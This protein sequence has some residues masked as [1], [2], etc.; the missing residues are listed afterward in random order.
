MMKKLSVLLISALALM[1][2]SCT[3]VCDN[4]SKCKTKPR[5]IAVQMW[6]LHDFTLA[7][8]LKQL[9]GVGTDAIECYPGQ[10]I[11]G[12][13][14]NAK[15]Q[16]GIKPAEL[17]YAKKL[18]K[19][20]GFKVV[21]FGVT[22]PFDEASIKANC[23]LAASLGAKRILTEARVVDFPIWD[24][25]CQEYGLTMCLHHHAL[26]AHNQYYDA[27]VVNKYTK[28]FK[29]IVGNPD[30]GHL[31]RSNISAVETIKQLKG[32]IGSIHTKDENA[33]GK[34][35]SKAC[36]LGKGFV[37]MPAVLKELDAQGYDGY[38]VIEYEDDWG[39]NVPHI[40]ACIEYLKNN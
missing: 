18:I 21:S 39:K 1:I 24:K 23:Q 5:K 13:Y 3:S 31:V 19:D 22:T 16:A 17:E 34:M 35:D 32:N 40:K 25:Y 8:A 26:D 7:D 37:D 10:T 9:Q 4:S 14:S 38:F 6:S 20:A 30:I 28:P 15:L 12:K 2:A 36:I 27:Y 11:G 33:F 29:N